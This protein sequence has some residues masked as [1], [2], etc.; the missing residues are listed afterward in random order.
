MVTN[1]ELSRG[2]ELGNRCGIGW[3]HCHN[4]CGFQDDFWLKIAHFVELMS[5]AFECLLP[6]DHPDGFL[7]ADADSI[8]LY[9]F[10]GPPLVGKRVKRKS[11]IH[12]LWLATLGSDVGCILRRAL[13]RQGSRARYP[14]SGRLGPYPQ[15]H[16]P[17]TTLFRSRS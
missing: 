12:S 8:D 10:G 16:R 17:V 6:D 13:E 1:R 9:S 4:I 15:C 3:I 11:V 7:L 5:D 14:L 2:V